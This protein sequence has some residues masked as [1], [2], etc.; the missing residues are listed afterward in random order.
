MKLSDE[1]K[2]VTAKQTL[3]EIREGM[4]QAEADM[5]AKGF[6]YPFSEPDIIEPEEAEIG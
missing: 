5:D 2:V 3:A 6:L 1:E 4:K